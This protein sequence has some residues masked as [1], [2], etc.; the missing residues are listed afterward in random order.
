[1]TGTS[2]VAAGG[3]ENNEA[4]GVVKETHISA[5]PLKS[6]NMEVLSWGK[7]GTRTQ[8]RHAATSSLAGKLNKGG[9]RVTRLLEH[10]RSLDENNNEVRV[11]YWK[12]L[13][14]TSGLP[15]VRS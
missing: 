11:R 7:N 5:S 10:L 9:G 6:G 14:K 1:L 15:N 3:E 8:N 13:G 2:D 12:L 4:S